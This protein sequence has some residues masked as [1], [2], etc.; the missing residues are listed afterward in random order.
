MYTEKGKYPNNLIPVILPAYTACEDGTEYFET[1]AHK[2]RTPGNRPKERI[3]HSEQGESLKSISVLILFFFCI[4][5][6]FPV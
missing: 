6:K 2:I 1:S 3:Q 5:S 4:N